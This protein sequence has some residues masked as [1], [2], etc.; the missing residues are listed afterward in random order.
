M[1]EPRILNA[2]Q[3]AGRLRKKD[4]WFYAHRAELEKDGFPEKLNDLGG[5]DSAAIDAWLDRKS[6]L[7]HAADPDLMKELETWPG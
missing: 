5:W 3:V 2:A 4:S 1:P 7:A 6:G